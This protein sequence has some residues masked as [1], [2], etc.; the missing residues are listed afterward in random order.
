MERLKIRVEID[1]E[2]VGDTGISPNS[3]EAWKP[4]RPQFDSPLL[5]S[6]VQIG[7]FCLRGG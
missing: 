3:F 6:F 4:S 1:I 7:G 5:D 2:A